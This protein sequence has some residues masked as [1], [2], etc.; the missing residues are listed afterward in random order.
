MLRLQDATVT[1]GRVVALTALSGEF[2][3]GTVS[4]LVGGDG[5]GK[6]TLLRLL[7]GR[8][9]AATPG[10]VK[11]EGPQGQRRPTVGYQGDGDGVWR[12]LS[13]AENVEFAARVHRLPAA[14]WQPRAKK[15][16][17]LAGLGE[18]GGRLAGRLSGGMRK[19]LGFVLAALHRPD[20]LL[21]D[22]PTTGVDP[23]SRAQIWA[24]LRA[25]AGEGATVVLATTYLDEAARADRVFFLADGDLLAVG[26]PAEV[27]AQAP[28]RIWRLAEGEECLPEGEECLPEGRTWNVGRARYGWTPTAQLRP[29]GAREECAPSL[30]NA[31][32]AL[33]LARQE[34]MDD[35]AAPPPGER[36]AERAGVGSMDG[37]RAEDAGAGAVGVGVEG[38]GT[39]AGVGVGVEAAGAA[40]GVGRPLARATGVRCRFGSFEALKGVDLEVRPGQV[41][42]LIGGNG[43]GKTTLMRIL[44]GLEQPSGGRAEL[45]GLAPG[46]QGRRHI[47]YL[48]QGLGLY[49]SL[50]ARQNL[51]LVARVHGAQIGTEAA[52]FAA[53]LGGAPVGGL[54]LGARRVLAF[55]AA[56]VHRPRLLILDE[57][58]SGLDPLGRAR[59]WQQLRMRARAGAGILVTTHYLQE[60]EQCDQLVLLREGE[61]IGAGAPAELDLAGLFSR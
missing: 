28:G 47:G 46:R 48:A 15:L 43:A 45:M 9:P 25:A 7:A 22:E 37:V 11:W 40:V 10:A 20:L 39:A 33:L 6:S 38:A 21:L 8:V 55:H 5:A 41:V 34:G 61:V 27:C 30:E 52:A 14:T 56:N 32:I 54:P 31:A 59:L 53:Q 17:E 35:A 42:G 58:T 2:R 1:Y 29:A 16:L 18:V 3:P 44:L 19:K 51:E 12:Q 26:T 13:V 49:P 24:L 60:A 36:G 57:P 23:D 4:A 50:N